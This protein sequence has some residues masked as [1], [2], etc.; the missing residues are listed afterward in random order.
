MMKI[1]SREK[2][3]KPGKKDRVM[4]DL[5]DLSPLRLLR[6]LAAYL[7]SRHPLECA[8]STALS[9]CFVSH[10]RHFGVRRQTAAATAL[11]SRHAWT[12]RIIPNASPRPKPKRC[13]ASLPAA[14][15][16]TLATV[17]ECAGLT[18]LRISLFG[19]RHSHPLGIQRCVKP[20]HSKYRKRRPAATLHTSLFAALAFFH[21]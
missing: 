18:A 7:N 10:L 4:I 1:V 12:R 11:S 5:L 19:A 20:Q 15:Q 14:V 6:L 13:R 21:G 9:I 8:G 17:L 2:T 16:N 3:Q